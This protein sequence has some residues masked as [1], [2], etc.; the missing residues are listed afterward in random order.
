MP[1]MQNEKTPMPL[2]YKEARI[3]NFDE[4][5]L[6][7]TEQ[8]MLNE[9]DRCL[10][11]AHKPCMQ[12]CPVQVNIPEFIVALKEK[13]P[14]LA[15]EIITKTNSFPAICGRVCPQES[16][17]EKHCVRAIKGEAVAIGRLERYAADHTNTLIKHEEKKNAK[18]VAVVGSGPAG[19]AC[20]AD[21]IK[22]GYDVTIYEALHEA[23]GVL[24]YG[25]PEFRL[26]KSIV[27]GQIE[28]LKKWGLNLQTNIIIGKT[29]T[30][31]ELKAQHVEAIFIGTGAGL[32]KFMNI[33]GENA[34]G[35]FSANELLTRVNLMKAYQSES[36]T[37]YFESEHTV[38][39]GGGNVA[40]DAARCARRL[41]KKVTIVYRRTIDEMPARK[42]EIE[43]A[44]EEDIDV[45][46]LSNPIEIIKDEK[47]FVQKIRLEKMELSNQDERGRRSV[48]KTG[49]IEEMD[50]D[51]VVMA[52][53]TTSNPLLIQSEPNLEINAK[54]CLVVNEDQETSLSCVYAG[55]DAVSGAATVI[56]ALGAGKKAAAQIIEKLGSAS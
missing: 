29:I 28:Q 21:L 17:C 9:A 36:E 44:L 4:V 13:N 47:G 53:G 14:D 49:I 18:K 2:Q 46:E 52:I 6:G 43:H 5:A 30:L 39:V 54:G 22:A 19:L 45:K 31:E 23:G 38:V 7:Y 50:C 41:G 1:N 20:A 56:L 15:Y 24:R 55:G 25:I 51:C 48:V 35:V 3:N 8:E 11:C 33:P 10:N 12:G 27:D 40:M 32:P 34:A 42:E 16:Q 37:P 26:P